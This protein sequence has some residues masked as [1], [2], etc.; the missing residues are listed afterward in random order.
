MATKIKKSID[1][2]V[3]V[4]RPADSADPREGDEIAL[5]NSYK[6][7]STADYAYGTYKNKPVSDEMRRKLR[8][9]VK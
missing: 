1:F 9:E 8:K 4:L 3:W 7:S 2:G 6:I 5:E